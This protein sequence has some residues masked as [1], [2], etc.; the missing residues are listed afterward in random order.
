MPS[1]KNANQTS[2]AFI[3]AHEHHC[4]A[5]QT[6]ISGGHGETAVLKHEDISNSLIFFITTIKLA[7]NNL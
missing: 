5:M 1:S 7:R 6:V 3:G 2:V 4:P